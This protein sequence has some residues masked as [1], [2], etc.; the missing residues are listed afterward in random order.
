MIE[1]SYLS[2]S[3]GHP[4]S[5]PVVAELPFL[6]SCFALS[7]DGKLCYPDN[8]SGFSIAKSNHQA[9]S[10]EQEADWWFL[11]LARSISDALIIGSNSLNL[12]HGSYL[13]DINIPELSAI[14]DARPLWTI[15]ICRNPAKLDFKQKLFSDSNYPVIICCFDDVGADRPSGF[16]YY[17]LN[18]L[19]TKQQLGIKNIIKVD[20]DLKNLF[21]KLKQ[22][23]FNIIL[24]ESPFFHHALLEYK[25]LHEFW[26]NYSCSYIGGEITSLGNK[27]QSFSSISHPDTEILTLHHIDYH[28]LYSRQKIL[29]S[30]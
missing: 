10:S 17:N 11:M 22:I 12:E 8:R 7:L 30:N 23:G 25:L 16:N 1:N 19:N 6:F 14:R 27:Q 15:V 2:D 18:D 5:L 20:G 24:N 9:T 21:L 28:F 29:Y 4:L 3:L 26:L 13:P